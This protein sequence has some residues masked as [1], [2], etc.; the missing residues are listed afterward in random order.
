MSAEAHPTRAAI[1]ARV[2]TGGQS[3]DSQ[4]A[5]LRAFCRSN[6][7]LIAAEYTDT[8]GGADELQKRPG[9]RKLFKRCE[10]GHLDIV[11]VSAIDRLARDVGKTAHYLLR[12]AEAEVEFV[13]ARERVGNDPEGRLVLN[14]MAAVA[15][16]ERARTRSR[17]RAGVRA[18]IERLEAAGKKYGRPVKQI[19]CELVR[20]LRQKG[21][22][23][24]KIA[25]SLNMAPATLHRAYVRQTGSWFLD[26][27][28][29]EALEG[30][31]G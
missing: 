29:G 23:V 1:Y 2:S 25:K 15:E 7:W 27:H 4:I 16:F 24:R 3:V 21:W 14:I 28:N 12:L 20:E 11:V 17:I 18:K 9:L 31:D 6:G 30:D 13:S 8:A 26:E 22:P 10:K 19:D 5:E